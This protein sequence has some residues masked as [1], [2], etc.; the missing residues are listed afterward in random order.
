MIYDTINFRDLTWPMSTISQPCLWSSSLDQAFPS[1]PAIS[2][3]GGQELAMESSVTHPIQM[4]PIPKDSRIREAQSRRCW[5][6]CK[7]Q[8]LHDGEIKGE[9][10]EYSPACLFVYL[11]ALIAYV[12]LWRCFGWWVWPSACLV[13]SAGAGCLQL[14][15]FVLARLPHQWNE[16]SC[17]FLGLWWVHRD[18]QRQFQSI[19]GAWSHQIKCRWF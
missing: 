4:S 19:W 12:G 9:L 14:Q 3:V 10:I 2:A 11:A 16:F 15:L 17:E 13:D 18:R 1:W 7:P 5:G 6:V 8:T